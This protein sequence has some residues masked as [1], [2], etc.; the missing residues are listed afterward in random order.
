MAKNFDFAKSWFRELEMSNYMINKG[1][2][3][4]RCILFKNLT[5]I[6]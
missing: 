3:V 5:K 2:F 1:K 6:G 4:I